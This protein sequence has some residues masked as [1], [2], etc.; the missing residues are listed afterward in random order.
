MGW[1]GCLP[2]LLC[3]VWVKDNTTHWYAL[4]KVVG[5]AYALR[6]YATI[7]VSIIYDSKFVTHV[8]SKKMWKDI[9][10]ISDYDPN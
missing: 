7:L 8:K 6:E 5:H 1:N 2:I 4:Q 3:M 9:D 10:H